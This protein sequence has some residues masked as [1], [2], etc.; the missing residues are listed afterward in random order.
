MGKMCICMR[1]YVRTVILVCELV[2]HTD[3]QLTQA[4]RTAIAGAWRLHVRGIKYLVRARAC[5][6][7]RVHALI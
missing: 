3:D 1:G 2:S 5:A 6:C 7:I 4:R